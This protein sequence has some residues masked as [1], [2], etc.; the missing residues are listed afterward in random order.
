MKGYEAGDQLFYPTSAYQPRTQ[1]QN[2]IGSTL[3]NVN[4]VEDAN[5]FRHEVY[6]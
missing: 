1:P 2:S 6:A 3:E 5:D 4:K